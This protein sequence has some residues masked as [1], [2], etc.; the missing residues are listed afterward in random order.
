MEE[1]KNKVKEI[2]M[3][4]VANNQDNAKNE[5][6]K[7]SYEQLKQAAD[8][9]WNE[10]RVLRQ[11]L[12]Q[13]NDFINTVNRLDYLLKIIEISHNNRNNSVSF[14][15]EFIEL[16]IDEVQKGMTPPETDSSTVENK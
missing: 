2:K 4:S 13:A 3:Q 9:L 15:S 1:Q 5:A 10:N 11:K 16:C 8:Q 6:P 14:S 12:Q 7:L